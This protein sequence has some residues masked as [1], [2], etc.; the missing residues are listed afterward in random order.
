MDI[1]KFSDGLYHIPGFLSNDPTALTALQAMIPKALRYNKKYE[2]ASP[3]RFS[4]RFLLDS[5]N[6][7]FDSAGYSSLRKSSFAL[8]LAG[9]VES[10]VPPGENSCFRLDHVGFVRALPGAPLQ[11][12]HNDFANC[13]AESPR[14]AVLF[15]APEKIETQNGCTG[16]LIHDDDKRQDKST[17]I[18]PELQA[19]D[20]ILMRGD[21]VHRGGYNSSKNT[22]NLVF[23]VF[24]CS[25]DF[26]LLPDLGCFTPPIK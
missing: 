23:C 6:I 25:K 16:F 26:K 21:I 7:F 10:L 17:W 18:Y 9:F 19:G 8:S 22:R 1:N 11:Q 2:T 24:D 5:G 14:K 4:T 13:T 15:I 20:A 3:K 12:E